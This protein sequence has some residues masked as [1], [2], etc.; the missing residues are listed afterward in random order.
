MEADIHT[1]IVVAGGGAAGIAAAIA[2][3]R[4]GLQVLLIER[5][6]YPGGKATA[7]EVGTVC[8]LYKF[9]KKNNAQYLV[10]GFAK[11]FAAI[12]QNKSGTKALF[13]A[14][15]LHYLPYNIEDFKSVSLDYLHE[16]KVTAYFDTEIKSVQIHQH[17][18]NAVTVLKKGQPVNIHLQSII[19]CTGGSI[20]S[21]A[22]HLPIIET[23]Q[24]QAAAQ[25]F[26][27][28]GIEE[29]NEARLG[30][31]ITKALSKAITENLLPV[32]YNR[33]YIVPGS[34]KNNTVSFKVGIPIA[35]TNTPNN[36][37][38]L[39]NTAHSFVNNLAAFLISNVDVFKN[40]S[41]KNI[42]AEVGTR[43]GQR[44][45][46][47]YILTENDVLACKKFVDGIANASWPIEEW[48][49]D[50]RVNMRYLPQDDYYQVP[51]ACLQSASIGN[52]FFAGRNISATEAAIA[53]ARVMGICL[54]TGYAAGCLAA[55][56]VKNISMADAVVQIQT[57][58]L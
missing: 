1:D 56:V 50:R 53:S 4:Q 42:A 58:Q 48:G 13:N 41:I 14:D 11:E 44:N 6:A 21:Q 43:T 3:A 9:N 35:V 15:G 30:L 28:T 49:Q 20:I 10:K 26:R 31:I 7:A 19:D 37:Q 18:I 8:G 46:G 57:S 24:Y 51:A 16:N 27:M 47:K 39:K 36:L 40:A 23:N 17:K 25:V 12:L 54:Q 34:L 22:A 2:A 5:N 29:I 32:F 38:D 45:L 55:A 52:L 33:V